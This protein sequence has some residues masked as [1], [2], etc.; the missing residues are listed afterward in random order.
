M[1]ERRRWSSASWSSATPSA[2]CRD[3][4]A[5]AA[6]PRPR[7]PAEVGPP[8]ARPPNRRPSSSTCAPRT[9]R[10][11]SILLHRLARA[12]R[13]VGH[14]RGGARI[15]GDVPRDL[16]AV[17]GAGAV[18]PPHRARRPRHDGRSGGHGAH[19]RARRAGRR[20]HRA[21]RAPRPGAARRTCPTRSRR[22]STASPAAAA[23]DTDIG[24][25]MD[26]LGPL[27][28]A[29]RYGDVRG[30]DV[31]S[32]RALFDEFVV[33][34]LA[35][36]VD[37]MVVARRRRRGAG[38]SGC[39][40]CRPRWPSSITRPGTTRFP[41]VLARI[42]DGPGARPGHRPGHPAA[43]RRRRLEC[44]RRRAA[45]RPRPQPRHPGAG[46]RGVRRGVPRRQSAPCS[47]TTPNCWRS[48]TRGWRR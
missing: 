3:G 25:V 8:P 31:A 15:G 44:R 32:L 19:R 45:A 13:A 22:R 26:G 18:D 24:Q 11:R 40:A 2:R 33:R 34:V 1:G 39:R 14:G 4:A 41:H 30:T 42:A 43:A 46:G 9:G 16:A 17:V 10:R 37:S 23:L 48:S 38:S 29:L 6:G 36:A 21:D 5:G 47:C 27:G 20:A 35:G 28:H 12:R 7:A